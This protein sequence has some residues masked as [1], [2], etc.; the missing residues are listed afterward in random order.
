MY[1]EFRVLRANKILFCSFEL[2]FKDFI[3]I[4]LK[5]SFR[6]FLGKIEFTYRKILKQSLKIYIK[7]KRKK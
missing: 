4:K 7:H 5:R 6:G 3:D 1:I 2:I